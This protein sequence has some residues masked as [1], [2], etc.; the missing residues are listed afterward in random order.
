M[1]PTQGALSVPSPPVSEMIGHPSVMA[2]D[3]SLGG[4]AYTPTPWGESAPSLVAKSCI[5]APFCMPLMALAADEV[6]PA[7]CET[8]FDIQVVVA[9]TSESS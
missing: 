9:S 1:K 6:E 5:D 4:M 3:Q 8:S 2:R 7:S